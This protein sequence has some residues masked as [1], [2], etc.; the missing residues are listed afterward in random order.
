MSLSDVA[1]EAGVSRTTIYKRLGNKAAILAMLNDADDPSP[2]DWDVEAR[3]MQGV[4]KVATQRGFKAATVE[5]IAEAAGVGPATIYRRYATKDE[6]VRAFIARR[7]PRDKLPGFPDDPG[8]G[9]EEHLRLI[10]DHLAR[11]MGENRTLVRLVFSGSDED[12]AYLGSLRD[13]SQST[14]S[15][16]T[17]FFRTHQDSG[18]ISQNLRPED[19]TTCL[20]GMIHAHM[21]IAPSG[22]PAERGR[23]VDTICSLFQSLICGRGA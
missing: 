23:I 20:F 15:R 22:E 14:F 12:R 2:L 16:L 10:V 9:F 5:A 7:T 8:A 18:A 17:A 3:I 21:V 1:A 19:L 6:L 4:L 11:F 13:A